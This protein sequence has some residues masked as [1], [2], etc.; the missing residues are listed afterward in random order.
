MPQASGTTASA[1]SGTLSDAQLAE[2]ARQGGFS[3]S[4]IPTAVAIAK[5]ESG[6]NPRAHNGNASTGDNSYGLWQINMIGS[7]GP[8]R[9][10]AFGI[11]T[12]EQLFDPATNARAA[13][14]VYKEQGWDAWSVYKSGSYKSQM[15]GASEGTAGIGELVAGPVTSGIVNGLTNKAVDQFTEKMRLAAATYLVFLVALVLLVLGVVILNKE[16]LAKAIAAA[17]VGKVAKV[18]K[19]LK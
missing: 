13:H 9:R 1:A 14:Q 3:A 8:N 10:K 16:N 2:F 4:E 7:M 17:P 12:N 19:V 6:A 5:A 18:A 11:T 15:G